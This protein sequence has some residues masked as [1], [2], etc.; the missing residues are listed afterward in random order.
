MTTIPAD[1]PRSD[2]GQWWWD[3]SQWQPVAG[4]GQAEG[5]AVDAAPAP[6]EA[7]L[8]AVGDTGPEAAENVPERLQSY[9]VD[10][11]PGQSGGSGEVGAVLDDSQF[12]EAAE[13]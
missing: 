6:S 11:D 7:E 5:S 8:R 1:A 4:D 9:F 10:G 2:D 3:G 13:A 12:G